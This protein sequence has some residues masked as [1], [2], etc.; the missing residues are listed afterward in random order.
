MDASPVGSPVKRRHGASPD[1]YASRANADSSTETRKRGADE[2]NGKTSPY[3]KAKFK[4]PSRTPLIDMERADPSMHA[5]FAEGMRDPLSIKRLK[6]LKTVFHFGN[7]QASKELARTTQELDT[8]SER[9]LH[10]EQELK[11]K[12]PKSMS[13]KGTREFLLEDVDDDPLEVTALKKAIATLGDEIE[14]TQ[15]KLESIQARLDRHAE[16]SDPAILLDSVHTNETM[17][18][19]H[20]FVQAW[21]AEQD[22]YLKP[23]EAG[24]VTKHL[25]TLASGLGGYWLCFGPGTVVGTL[26]GP[27]AGAALTALTG[28]PL[29]GYAAELLLGPLV[30]T[31]SWTVCE[32]LLAMIRAT[33]WGNT[34]LESYNEY[35]RLRARA[36]REAIDG[37][38]ALECNR[39]FEWPDAA[40][41]KT[42]RLNAAEYLERKG[43]SLS[44][45]YVAKMG[46]SDIPYGIYAISNS[47]RN[48]MPDM[49]GESTLYQSLGYNLGSRL[50]AGTVAG[51]LTAEAIQLTRAWRGTGKETVTM[52]RATWHLL[53]GYLESLRNNCD[54]R[55]SKEK[56]PMRKERLQQVR[57]A[58]LAMLYK[59]RQKSGG[60]SSISYELETLWQ[61]KR[62]AVGVDVEAPG[63]RLNTIATAIGKFTSQVP[64]ALAAG[65]AKPFIA[66]GA[67]A[68]R[69]AASIAAPSAQIYAGFIFRREA[70]FGA[71]VAFGALAGLR[72]R[73]LRCCPS[74]EEQ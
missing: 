24:R 54:D 37:T 19:W 16:M 12:A 48:C 27:A 53:A 1:G 34:T 50:L 74:E 8:L 2:T 29:A 72:N 58:V 28:A 41:G 4:T 71:R 62:E 35:E 63:K 5:P 33:S 51:P 23:G 13:S 55:I 36:W 60:F 38:S 47:I 20:A 45:L 26:Y 18:K 49:L 42:L 3:H 68:W 6:K 59:A 73:I 10:L 32:P 25:W 57:D 66:S 67:L 11:R 22:Y 17:A 46:D 43:T 14:T 52:S 7:E 70:E 64:G 30:S 40:S 15:A 31:I 65:L 9:L 44:A 21:N 61:K 69:T 39:K 56:E